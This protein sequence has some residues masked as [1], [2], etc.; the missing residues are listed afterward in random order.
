MP[1]QIRETFRPLRPRLAYCI[2]LRAFSLPGLDQDRDLVGTR[3]DEVEA[4][5]SV[6]GLRDGRGDRGGGQG[7]AGGQDDRVVRAAETSIEYQRVALDAV[8]LLVRVGLGDP[9]AHRPALRDRGKPD[10][11]DLRVRDDR[12]ADVER[13]LRDLFSTERLRLESFAGVED[14]R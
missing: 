4:D 7:P 14:L 8:A 11:D 12:L 5:P 1:R 10:D 3:V 2:G 9:Q 6:R 13:R